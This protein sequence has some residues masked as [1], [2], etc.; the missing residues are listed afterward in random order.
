MQHFLKFPSGAARAEIIPAH[1]FEQLLVA[2]H[3]AETRV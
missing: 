1:F 2:M 3:Y